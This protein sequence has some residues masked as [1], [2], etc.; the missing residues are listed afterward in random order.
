MQVRLVLILILTGL[1]VFSCGKSEEQKTESAAANFDGHKVVVQE[2]I[3]ATS[4]TYLRVT[5]DDREYWMAVTKREI[6]EGATQ[7]YTT[8]MEMTDFQSKDLDRTFAS[9]YFVQDLMDQPPVTA[10]S[11]PMAGGMPQGK[12][13]PPMDA[14][15]SVEPAAG[16]ITIAQ[17]YAHK[18]DYLYKKVKVRGK[19]TKYNS[20]IMSRNWVH[21]QDGTS[22][23][24]NYDV[25]VTTQDNVKIGDVV[26]F[27][28]VV[29]LD[30]DF[31]AGYK[32]EVI[33]EEASLQ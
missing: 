22:E 4:Y 28:G 27:E 18:N 26:T 10:P 31:G 29:S 23:E 9:I 24:G 8:G 13:I 32:Y 30:K 14:S 3:Q 15:L 25:A 5:E 7:Y 20:G 12:K 1:F 19:V 11:M 6:A 17:L 33:I 21:L 2:V 16:G